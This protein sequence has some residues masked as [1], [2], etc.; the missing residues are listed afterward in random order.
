M[1]SD[2]ARASAFRKCASA[3]SHRED[4]VARTPLLG[5]DERRPHGRA[6]RDDGRGRGQ[7]PHRPSRVPHVRRNV[8]EEIVAGQEGQGP[9]K[10]YTAHSPDW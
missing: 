6:G 3:A 5:D 10:S 7:A 2:S 4:L 1:P 8:L 9:P